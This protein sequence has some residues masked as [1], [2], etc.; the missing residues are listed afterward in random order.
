MAAFI[1]PYNRAVILIWGCVPVACRSTRSSSR[2]TRNRVRSWRFLDRLG[3]DAT[4]AASGEEAL[5][6][7]AQGQFDLVF[8]DVHMPE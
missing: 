6:A 7:L 2:M 5:D 3:F 8:S 4:E 1:E